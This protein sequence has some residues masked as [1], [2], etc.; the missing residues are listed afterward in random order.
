MD[1]Q[2]RPEIKIGPLGD[3]IPDTASLGKVLILTSKS[4]NKAH[5]IQEIFGTESCQVVT[6][7]EPELP[8]SYIENLYSSRKERKKLKCEKYTIVVILN[9]G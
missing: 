7:V 5:R 2:V 3:M 8:F 6:D 4:L 1:Y 9:K